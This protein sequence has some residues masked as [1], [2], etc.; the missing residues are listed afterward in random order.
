MG[1]EVYPELIVNSDKK[2]SFADTDRRIVISIMDHETKE[3]QLGTIRH[4]LEHYKQNTM[5]YRAFGREEYI[6]ALVQNYI[7]KLKYCDEYCKQYFNK[8]YPQ[9]S[10][11]EIQDFKDRVINE[12]YPPNSFGKLE[13]MSKKMGQIK[14]NTEE[15]KEA[16]KYLKAKR[17][18]VSIHMIIKNSYITI[19]QIDDIADN[20]PEKF[21]ILYDLMEK[22]L[23]NE[24]EKGAIKEQNKI[25]EMYKLYSVIVQK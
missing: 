16:E 5:T 9:L 10:K 23:D 6:D 18:Y 2:G 17:E 21:K 20:E 25:K 11:E 22:N 1:F 7:S 8:T 12:V 4:E 19:K 15:Y 13:Y 3:E 14:P 24:L